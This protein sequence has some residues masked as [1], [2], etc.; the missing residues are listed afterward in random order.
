MHFVDRTNAPLERTIPADVN[1]WEHVLVRYFLAVGR[2]GDASDIHAIEVSP[3]TLALACGIDP[4]REDEVEEAF[5]VALLRDPGC[6]LRALRDGPQ[7][8]PSADVPNCFAMLAMTLLIDLLLEGAAETGNQFRAKLADWLRIDRTFSDLSGV[9]LMWEELARWLEKRVAHGAPF[10]RLVLPDPKSWHHIGYTRRLSFPNRADVRAV[11]QVLAAVPERDLDNPVTVIQAAAQLGNRRNISIGLKEAYDDFVQSY[12]SQRRAIADH[13]FWRLAVQAR[14]VGAKPRG[15]A[16][17]DISLTADEEREFR[18]TRVSTEEVYVH[19]ALSAALRDKT[20]TASS[21]LGSAVARGL[22]FFRQV[23]YGHWTAEPDLA[24]CRSRVLVAFDDRISNRPCERLGDVIRDGRWRLTTDSIDAI[25]VANELRMCGIMVDASV[26]LFRPMALDGV[27]VYGAWLGLPPFLPAIDADTGQLRVLAEGIDAAEVRIS[28]A[29]S[30]RLLSET[31]IA[32]SYLVEP[33]LLQR[34]SRPPWRLR[35]QFV[36]RAVPHLKLGGKRKDL[37]LLEDWNTTGPA[38]VASNLPCNVGWARTHNA[39]E[40]LL[41]A[42]YA[43]GA[44]GWDESEIVNLVRRAD[45]ETK[46]APWR[47]LRMLQEGGVI[48]PR[49]R[50]RWKGR[51][52][53]LLPPRIVVAWTDDAPIALAEGALCLNTLEAFEMATTGMG[54]TPFRIPGTARWS[55]PVTGAVGVDPELLACRLGWEFVEQTETP[56]STPMGL[57]KTDRTAENYKTAF[58]WCWRDRRFSAFGATEA[59]VRLTQLSHPTAADHD[60]YRVERDGE[61]WHFLSRQAAIV[62]AHAVA[63]V[64]LFA[65]VDN[66]LEVMAQDGGLPDK[67][68]TALRRCRLASSGFAHDFYSYPATIEDAVWLAALL[69]GCVVGASM[70]TEGSAGEV[71]S[72]SRHSGGALRVQWREGRLTL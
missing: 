63:R 3:R 72:R 35:L 47:T 62:A 4:V 70:R 26:R 12:Y 51:V 34:E 55:V 8:H 57:A 15:L 21:N 33:H 18:V 10:R 42:L 1:A 60:V 43:S 46:L 23:G 27:R 71:L 48:E 38:R 25:K 59:E 24:K 6:L 5:R 7:R 41:E 16:A 68:A 28:T 52:W 39:M 19:W 9:K 40:W 22:L 58:S 20:L 13:R 17:F 67:L 44:H 29:G 36:D 2:E 32:G 69:P 50:Q 37:S 14:A 61:R 49:L 56:L 53:T 65:F 11:A 45:P 66:R 54:G 30:I 31:S 64:P